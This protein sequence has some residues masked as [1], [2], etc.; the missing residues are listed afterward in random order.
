MKKLTNLLALAALAAVSSAQIARVGTYEGDSFIY[1]V[2]GS[3]NTGYINVQWSGY[4]TPST[5]NVG[6]RV[7]VWDSTMPQTPVA[8][9][10]Y[11]ASG[12]EGNYSR[13]F[14]VTAYHPIR[15]ELYAVGDQYSNDASV[16]STVTTSM[17]VQPISTTVGTSYARPT[18]YYDKP[19]PTPTVVVPGYMTNYT[20]PPYTRSWYY[21]P[22]AVSTYSTYRT[23]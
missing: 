16:S 14:A 10:T 18:T 2:N 21:N 7:V 8:S 3:S 11:H 20:P 9:E 15:V 17:L 1:A 13:T 5:S 19:Y 6:W 4:A 12:N 23:P 22:I